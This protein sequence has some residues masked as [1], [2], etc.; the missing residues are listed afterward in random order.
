MID[1]EGAPPWSQEERRQFRVCLVLSAALF[2]ACAVFSVGFYHF[3]E[4]FQ[5]IEFASVK[6]GVSDPSSLTWEYTARVR[7]WL[8]PALYVGV[9][10]AAGLVGIDNAYTLMLLMR[11]VTALFSWSALWALVVAGR[12]WIECEDDRCRLYWIAA[13][14]WLL[15]YL[16]AR[17]S[18][19]TASTAMLCFGIA[20]L[21]WRSGR[22]DSRTAFGL[23]LTAGL[24]LSLCFGLRY[25]SGV[26]AAAVGL[27]HL[28]ADKRRL[29]LT[30]GL[31]LGGAVGLGLGML[32]DYWGYGTVTF[33][34][35]SYVTQNFLL[36][37]AAEFGTSPFFAYLYLPLH[38]PMAPLVLLLMMATMLAWWRRPTS[39]LTV[40]TLP[41]VLLLSMT[42]HKEARFL[43]PLVPFL[44]F[45]V[46]FA[47]APHATA[48]KAAVSLLAWF[49]SGTR[50]RLML[51]LNAAAIV[52]ILIL[53]PRPYYAMYR[54]LEMM[55]AADAQKELVAIH[56]SHRVPYWETQPMWA[57][58]MRPRHL[59]ITVNPPVSE[60]DARRAAG[61]PFL[62]WLQFSI[63]V[64]EAT[65]WVESNCAL[66]RSLWPQWLHRHVYFRWQ[67]RIARIELYRC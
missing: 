31:V 20:L 40:A 41:Y 15:P 61:K 36:G 63:E 7:S 42:A 49:A 16:G 33:P 34:F 26:M 32:A 21:E 3:D 12:R 17:T 9:V 45:F 38:N 2:L 4:Y 62:V 14:L 56:G 67:R 64:L 37:R 28:V 25:P 44:P 19:E 1:R 57:T 10:K 35:V 53:P 11:L 24:A 59:R 6:L 54:L 51:L 60:L 50:L 13:L 66:V 58:F 5:V 18:A 52:F 46:A 30:M 39:V 22:V 27:W 48:A 29:S 47:L 23:A 65:P 43:F 8:Q 55:T